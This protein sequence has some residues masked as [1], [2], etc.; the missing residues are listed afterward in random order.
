MAD[1]G[2]NDLWCQDDVLGDFQPVAGSLGLAQALYRRWT[3]DRGSLI[4]DPMY[5]TNLTDYINADVTDG[6]IANLLAAAYAE[7]LKDERVIEIT[8]THELDDDGVLRI[9][10]TVTWGEG[11]FTLTLAVS[12]VTVELLTVE[13]AA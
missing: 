4:D 7:A 11:P 5:G 1:L 10:F 8:G 9:E 13:E 3:S 6:D 2:V 12:A